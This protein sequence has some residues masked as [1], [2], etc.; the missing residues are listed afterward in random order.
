M[1]RTRHLQSPSH[2]LSTLLTL[3]VLFL[4]AGFSPAQAQSAIGPGSA[5]V[6]SKFGGQIFGFDIDQ[7]GT[8]G[9]LT[10]ARTLR[11]GRVLAAVETFDQATGAIIKVVQ[12]TL[13]KDDF[14]TI[15]VVGDSVGLVE[16]EHVNT[17]FV[18]K[19]IYRTL[20]P[21][22]ANAFTGVWTP[23]LTKDD[24]I[25]SVSRLQGKNTTLFLYFNN[26]PDD[27]VRML[28]A[29]VAAN[30]VGV[31][32]NFT[33][34]PFVLANAPQIAYD[35]VRNQ[36][37]VAASEAAV[38]GPAPV[39]ALVDLNTGAISTFLGIRGPFPFRQ[40]LINGLAVDPEDGIAVTTTEVDFSVQFYDLQTKTGFSQP[41]PGATGQLQ[42][43]TDVQYDPI[44]KLFFVAQ[45]VSSTGP[46]SSIQIY[47][48]H[49]NFLKSLDGFNFSNRTRVIF[50]HIALNP[51]NR[52]GYVD[53]PDDSG[54]QLQSF[55]Y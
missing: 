6:T 52:S 27:H 39:I 13:S 8:E 17:L 46:G 10:E 55:T 45:S 3:I 22:S 49:G 18:D 19:R 44:N 2:V 7:N 11:D 41:L 33:D 50:T 53:G 5:I 40:G 1:K 48:I 35:N 26:G 30:T 9:V 12:K 29:D 37:V 36:A 38:G 42:S 43:G 20:N 47:D 25:S 15:G 54:T 32:V 31:Q 16:R 34:R 4:A 14:I 21:L 51:A 28:A 23:P 24:I